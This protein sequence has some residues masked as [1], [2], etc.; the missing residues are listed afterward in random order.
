MTK[1]S[2]LGRGLDALIPIEEAAPAES[3]TLSG[4]SDT[5]NG[6]T[7]T[8]NGVIEIPLDSISPNPRQPR[9]RFNPAELAELA[10]SIREH[11]I[12][13]P[14]IVKQNDQPGQFTLIAGE[15][16]LLAARQAALETV[17]VII[18]EATQQE[19]VELALIENVQRADLSPLE[20]AEA[21]RQLV[22]DFNLSHE[23]VAVR[24]GKSRVAV[25]NTLRLLKLPAVVQEAITDERI[26]EGHARALLALASTQAQSAALQTILKHDLNVRQ[27]EELVRKLSGERPPHPPSIGLP[28]E[29]AAVEDRLRHQLGTKVSINPSRKGGTVV[30][31]YYSDEDLDSL[32]E[33]IGAVGE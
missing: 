9:V 25:T 30:I 13:Q 8:L 32:I 16:R 22:E 14:L 2:G 11:G 7:E 29:L 33:R 4:L 23:A 19:L 15:R 5:L 21:Y 28:P 10:A 3:N 17:P 12:I 18:R 1:R 24:V 6:H 20:A 26:T 27:T 31:H